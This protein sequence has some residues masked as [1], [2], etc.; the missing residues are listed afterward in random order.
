MRAALGAGG[1][2]AVLLALVT[3]GVLGGRAAAAPVCSAPGTAIFAAPGPP[4]AKPPATV[5]LTNTI[6][7]TPEPESYWDS[8]AD[9]IGF[10]SGTAT[11]F[12][13][14]VNIQNLTTCLVK[15]FSVPGGITASSVTV[16]G[17]DFPAAADAI[18]GTSFAYRLSTVETGCTGGWR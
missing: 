6:Y 10:N 13:Y 9:L 12:A 4:L 3:A 18:S 15:S 16:S 2:V 1:I 5:G 11:G 17:N 8:N 14:R 7:W